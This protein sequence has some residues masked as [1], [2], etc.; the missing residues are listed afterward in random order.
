METAIESDISSSDV[1][2]HHDE[3]EAATPE[4]S[5]G[6]SYGHTETTSRKGGRDHHEDN[7]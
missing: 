7:H 5:I 3:H 6:D 4:V 1:A 2:Q